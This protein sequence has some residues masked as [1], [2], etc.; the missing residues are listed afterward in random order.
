MPSKQASQRRVVI[1][2]IGV[3]SSIGLGKDKFWNALKKGR[4][5]VSKITAFDPAE[6]TTQFAGEIKNF[7]PSDFIH[8]K[9][10][11]RMES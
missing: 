1:T 5:G 9:R 2:G 10:L 3:V 4:S 11:K 8:V 6:F 7:N